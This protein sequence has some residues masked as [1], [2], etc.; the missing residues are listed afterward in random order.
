[1]FGIL[2]PGVGE[3][4]LLLVLLVAGFIV[5]RSVRQRHLVTPSLAQSAG[6][7]EGDDF[8][9]LATNQRVTGTVRRVWRD[10]AQGVWLVELQLGKRRFA[11]CPVDYSAKAEQY[12]AL[13]GKD[14]DVALYALSTLAPGGVEAMKEQIRDYNKVEVTPDLVR[15][16]PVGQLANDHAVIGR[17]LS[18]RDDAMSDGTEVAVYRT[19]V[20]R[21]DDL[22]LVLELA[23]DTTSIAEPFA[24]QAMV[25]GSARLFGYL[26]D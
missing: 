9:S 19:Q 4:L 6:L 10:N 13:V 12:A 3:A 2:P 26:P 25:H 11:F 15:L 23:I 7:E 21:G 5:I 20:V 14:A 17:V 24:D 8:P 18:H 22:T 16:I 1:V